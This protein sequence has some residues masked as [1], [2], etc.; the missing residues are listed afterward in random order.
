MAT[1]SSQDFFHWRISLGEKWGIGLFP[2][3]GVTFLADHIDNIMAS[4]YLYTKTNTEILTQITNTQM[5]HREV[6]IKHEMLLD[7]IFAT[8]GGMCAALNISSQLCCVLAPDPKDNITQL[9]DIL[10]QLTDRLS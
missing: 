3:Y 10:T 2:W 8:E 9:L 4:L 5:N 1:F 6:I 7:F